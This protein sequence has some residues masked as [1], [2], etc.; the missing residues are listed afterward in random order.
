MNEA[1]NNSPPDCAPDCAQDSQR[2]SK[3]EIKSRGYRKAE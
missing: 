2:V 3:A 1:L